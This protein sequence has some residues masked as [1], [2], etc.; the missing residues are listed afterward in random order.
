V[1]FGTRRSSVFHRVAQSAG[2]I[3]GTAL[4]AGGN[5]LFDN[6]EARYYV[7]ER[8]LVRTQKELLPTL[9]A[10]HN[11][12]DELLARLVLADKEFMPSQSGK[13][14]QAIVDGNKVIQRIERLHD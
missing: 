13:P 2:N 9:K 11:A 5:H 7:P 3:H 4:T 12:V 8:E 14:W 10:Y 6:E 1:Q